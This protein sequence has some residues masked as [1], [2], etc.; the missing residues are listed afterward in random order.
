[1]A[2]KEDIIVSS[3]PTS[4]GKK[5]DLQMTECR[6]MLYRVDRDASTQ[7]QRLQRAQ[8]GLGEKKVCRKGVILQLN[9]K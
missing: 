6:G 5:T 3:N 4:N 8:L 1:M 7:I 2:G 9:L